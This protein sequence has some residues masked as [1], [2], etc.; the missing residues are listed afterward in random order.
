MLKNI[1]LLLVLFPL[2][3]ITGL[4]QKNHDQLTLAWTLQQNQYE[5]KQQALS[6]LRLINTG[7][8]PIPA[9]GWSLYFNAVR[10][11]IPEYT[12]PSGFDITALGGDWFRL[13]PNKNFSG[14]KRNGHWDIPLV[15]RHWLMNKADAPSG[16]YLVYDSNP[17][18]GFSLPPVIIMAPEEPAVLRRSPQDNAPEAT[19]AWIYEQNKALSLLPAKQVEGVF[20]T[21][22]Q[23][24]LTD[25]QYLVS[26]ETLISSDMPWK[27][28]A[29]MLSKK[30]GNLLGR[31]PSIAIMPANVHRAGIS[32]RYDQ[33]MSNPE[34]Y[35]L[36][37]DSTRGIIITAGHY[38][39][40]IY[41][42][43]SFLTLMPPVTLKQ[44]R[45]KIPFPGI[46]VRDEPRFSY[47]GLHVD[48]ARNFQSAETLKKIMDVMGLYKLNKL[49]LHFNDDEGW[50]IAIPGLPELTDVGG[51]R[52][53]TLTERDMLH[54]AY[55]SGPD[56]DQLTGSGHYSRE[57]FIDLIAYGKA[58]N[59]DIIPEIEMPGHA[60]AAIKSMESRYYRLLAEGKSEEAKQYLLNDLA[61]SS[62]YKSVQSYTDNVVCVCQMSTYRFIEK[63]LVELRQMYLAAGAEMSVVH[64]GGDE[65]P[66]GVWM[67]SP[68][69][70]ALM[71]ALGMKDGDDL[72][73]YFWWNIRDMFEAAGI[74]LAGWEEIGLIKEQKNGKSVYVPNP[75]FA[76]KQVLTY[77]WNNVIG[78]G[79]ED[80]AYQMANAGYDVVLGPVS[81]LYFD[82]AYQ[83][84]F[85]EPGYYWGAYTDVEKAFKF[86]PFDYFKTT[87]EDRLGNP[88]DS[89][90]FFGKESLTPFGKTK[91]AG[92]QGLI[93]S[94][95]IRSP[96][97][98][99]YM[100]FPKLLG[101]AERAWSQAPA[102]ET[103]SAW[104]EP[105]AAA[106]NRFANRLGQV[107]L[108]R[109]DLMGSGY[110]YRVPPPGAIIEQG[111]LMANTEHPGLTIRYTTD[112]TIPTPE[113]LIYTEPIFIDSGKTIQLSTFSTNGR[114]SRVVMLKS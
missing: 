98:L 33:S 97:Q 102:Y 56:A 64:M 66:P 30:L 65:V 2:S 26:A 39:G 74:Q 15:C 34:S 20:P 107:E 86:V 89:N 1:Y 70:R 68:E 22:A 10:G 50:R 69:C 109:L 25:E 82:M 6:K 23:M 27:D 17:G 63:V 72:W 42:I 76:D 94:E 32:L 37:I 61:D 91:I 9:R 46:S 59:I 99:S 36:D 24:D 29:A 4:A 35:T 96:E 84:H 28:V 81:N 77:V 114:S 110:A 87:T 18:K 57:V 100:V 85:E 43:Q 41:G 79:A 49:H 93:W 11:F 55:G 47:R 58:L 51:R 105:Y 112:G 45:G 60:R 95:T 101:L 78:W 104:E 21:P 83:Q 14:I 13:S 108:P 7:S 54:P 75:G 16:F 103:L 80:L 88:V 92:I 5:G 73:L 67:K 12:Q 38:G 19:P 8:K 62:E 44:F 3:A 52:G 71:T 111:W 40:M 113:S 31:N 53:H 106:W 90:I 48:I